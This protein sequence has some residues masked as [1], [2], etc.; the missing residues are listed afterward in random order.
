MS[1]VSGEI[2]TAGP[3][4]V[5]ATDTNHYFWGVD[6]FYSFD[7]NTLSRLPNNVRRWLISNMNPNYETQIAGV[8]D[9]AHSQIV[10]YFSSIHAS[11]IASPD[12]QL[13]FSLLP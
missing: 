3:Y 9:R 5:V 10:W 7:G 4:S 12:P 13:A 8:Y 2:G 6:D 1:K 11:P